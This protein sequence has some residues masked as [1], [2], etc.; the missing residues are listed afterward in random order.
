MWVS[1]R[2]S[3]AQ[4]FE[5]LRQQGKTRFLG[6]TAIGDTTAVHQVIDARAFD[7]YDDSS[8]ERDIALDSMSK[9]REG[10]WA[11]F[12]RKKLVLNSH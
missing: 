6:L 10:V 3:A 9:Q 1:Q 7:S 2:K 4:T 11:G 12:N 8:D 5:R